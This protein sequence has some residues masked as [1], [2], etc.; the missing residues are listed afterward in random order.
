M[1]LQRKQAFEEERGCL[2]PH[3]SHEPAKYQETSTDINMWTADNAHTRLSLAKI[4]QS[5]SK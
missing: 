3:I 5:D 2:V 4:T 1:Q